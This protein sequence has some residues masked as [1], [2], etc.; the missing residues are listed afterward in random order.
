MFIKLNHYVHFNTSDSVGHSRE[1]P[2]DQPGY[3]G[4]KRSPTSGDL[5]ES[6][7]NDARHLSMVHLYK[8]RTPGDMCLLICRNIIAK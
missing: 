4:Q 2:S 5:E 6:G 3:S 7:T 1:H 8:I